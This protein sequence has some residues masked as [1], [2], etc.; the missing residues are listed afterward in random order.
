MTYSFL[1]CF[2]FDKNTSKLESVFRSPFIFLYYFYFKKINKRFSTD[3]NMFLIGNTKKYNPRCRY[4]YNKVPV[5]TNF[6]LKDFIF[7]LRGHTFMTSE[8]GW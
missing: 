5:L 2:G 3:A 6:L 7:L 8:S 4:F 1:Y